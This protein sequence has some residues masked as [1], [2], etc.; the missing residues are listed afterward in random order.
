MR[1]I[2]ICQCCR[3]RESTI[4]TGAGTHLC[5]RCNK[6]VNAGVAALLAR[7]AFYMRLAFG[8]PL[9]GEVENGIWTVTGPRAIAGLNAMWN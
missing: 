3:W 4:T 9:P 6:A 8:E 2:R 1:I 5:D 7:D